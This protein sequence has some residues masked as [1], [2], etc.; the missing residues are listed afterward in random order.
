MD[1]CE[2]AGLNCKRIINEPTAA[3]VAYG[4]EFRQAESRKVFVFD[5]GGGTFDV[6]VLQIED[7]VIE[8]LASRGDTHFGG[9]DFD[10]ILVEYCVKD[11]LTKLGIVSSKK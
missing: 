10:N 4:I 2:I 6:S 3:A 7:G 8:V 9:Q 11:V 1:A 5:L